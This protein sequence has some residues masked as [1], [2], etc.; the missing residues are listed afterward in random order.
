M[1]FC[2][3]RGAFTTQRR[4]YL[5]NNTHNWFLL[6]CTVYVQYQV[7]SS[8]HTTT[9]DMKV[10]VF[11]TGWLFLGSSK[12]SKTRKVLSL[13]TPYLWKK[14]AIIFGNLLTWHLLVPGDGA[15]VKVIE[16]NVIIR[17]R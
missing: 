9:Y 7:L 1:L 4:Q 14:K 5:L 16:K 13:P 11:M 6:Y 3:T 17:N 10:N 8:L 15:N 12:N 2:S